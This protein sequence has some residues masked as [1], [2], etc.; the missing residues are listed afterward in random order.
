[1]T[2]S[3]LGTATSKHLAPGRAK[4]GHLSL[5]SGDEKDGGEAL[6]ERP[7]ILIVDDEPD[8]VDEIGEL[9]EGIGFQVH[10]SSNAFEAM[11]ILDKNPA[12]Q[13]VLTDIRMPEM[14]GLEMARVILSERFKDRDI[15]LIVMTGHAGMAEAIEALQIGAQDFLTKPISPDY[16]EHAVTKAEE[17]VRLR[18]YEKDFVNELQK[19]VKEKTAQAQALSWDLAEKNK[20]LMKSNRELTTL[21]TLKD[22]FLGMISHELNTPLNAINGFAHLVKQHFAEIHDRAGEE[23]ANHIIEGSNRLMTSVGNILTMAEAQSGKLACHEE[24]ILLN[25]V[26]ESSVSALADMGR[27][28]KRALVHIFNPDPSVLI[29]G[30]SRLL[31]QTIGVLLDNASKFS[32]RDTEIVVS[33]EAMGDDIL[34]TVA[35]KGPGMSEETIKAALEPLRQ[36]DG[37]LTRSFEGMGLGLPLA[38]KLMEIMGGALAIESEPGAGTKV[39]LKLKNKKVDGDTLS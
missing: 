6:A 27:D 37:S 29:K 34:I 35:D 12:I 13:I 23:K 9:I 2:P 7:A 33:G 15:A 36:A 14:D 26:L 22:E 32:S 19:A 10:G 38:R 4:A 17:M 24:T 11:G 39:T 28:G 5:A 21:G 1:M 16:L 3:F 25:D 31:R 8:I 18:R 20:E 30:D